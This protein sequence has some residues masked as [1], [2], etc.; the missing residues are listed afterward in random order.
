MNHHYVVCPKCE[1]G[2]VP[3][4][5]WVEGNKFIFYIEPWIRWEKSEKGKDMFLLNE[6]SL[7]QKDRVI[8]L[9]LEKKRRKKIRASTAERILNSVGLEPNID[10]I[11]L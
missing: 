7:S 5:E 1:H 10:N 8:I 9:E 4:K 11:K 3:S 6:S 2:F